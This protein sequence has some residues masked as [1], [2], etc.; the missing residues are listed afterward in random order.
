M[1]DEIRKN[2]KE[3]KKRVETYGTPFIKQFN[4]DVLVYARDL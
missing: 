2:P 4:T 3:N 1:Y